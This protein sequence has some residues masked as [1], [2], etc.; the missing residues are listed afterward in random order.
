VEDTDET[1]ISYAFSADNKE[2]FKLI[3]DAGADIN[4]GRSAL[5]ECMKYGG[6]G[7][8]SWPE[9]L[10]TNGADPNR[11]AQKQTDFCQLFKRS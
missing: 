6:D 2:I 8:D 4:R 9:F 11:Q 1:A 10:L 5:A 3:L 7:R